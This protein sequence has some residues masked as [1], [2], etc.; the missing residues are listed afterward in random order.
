MKIALVHKRLDL[1]GGTERDLYLTAEGLRDLGHEVH[2]FCSEFAVQVPGGVVAHRVPVMPFGRTARLW[3]FALN[4][5]RTAASA[6]CDVTVG[7]GRIFKQ[8]VLRSGGG[9]HRY[10][11]KQLGAE[12]GWRRRTWQKLSI[13]HRSVLAI[14][15]RQYSANRF[16]EIVA[17]SGKVKDDLMRIY[18]IPEH[19]IRVIYNGV[20]PT[21]FTPDRREKARGIIRDQW[22][23]PRDAAV[24][25]FIGNGFQRKGL[26]RLLAV[27]QSQR[28]QKT[29]LLVVGDD[30]GINRYKKLAET[31]GQ[32][33]ILFTGRQADVESYYGAA[34]L[35]ALPAAQE[36][37]GNVVLE[38]LSSGLPVLVSREVGAAELLTGALLQG[39]VDKPEDPVELERKLVALLEHAADPELINEAKT[40]AARFSWQ[41]HFRELEALLFEVASTR[42]GGRADVV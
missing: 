12:G 2:L 6:K 10:F 37:F 9:S 19:R 40:V 41:N 4:G 8:D 38:A 13:Y 11:L 29:W 7:F 22:A 23:I 39:I 17:V 25:L 5:S 18:S 21:R 3:S 24:V 14:E 1:K 35:L 33:R 34:D 16:T 31:V 42:C 32:G 26:D 36:A 28:L 30:A 15:R 27:W 20:D